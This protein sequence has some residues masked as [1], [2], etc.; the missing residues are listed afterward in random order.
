MAI[1]LSVVARLEAAAGEAVL[2][3]A[4]WD[5]G[6][7]EDVLGVVA[8]PR[9]V[10]GGAG[11]LR[12][13]SGSRVRKT[14]RPEKGLAPTVTE[15][16][17]GSTRVAYGNRFSLTFLRRVGEGVHPDVEVGRFLTERAAFPHA[18]PVLGTI[19]YGRRGRPAA[20]VAVLRGAG[21]AGTDG[22][23]HALDH[24]GRFFESALVRRA[25]PPPAPPAGHGLLELAGR[26]LP[27]Q[28]GERIGPFLADAQLMGRRTAEMGEDPASWSTEPPQF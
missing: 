2:Y 21:A 11:E 28:A 15:G 6:F 25:A 7:C 1:P 3:D 5:R 16:A 23:R 13:A 9:T 19:E 17:R 20:T 26:G 8:R 22:L 18:L 12:G 24:L 10:Q 27:A 4:L 14:R